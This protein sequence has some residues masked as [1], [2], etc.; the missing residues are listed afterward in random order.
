MRMTLMGTGT[1]HGV[2]VIACDC[3]VCR[4]S[5]KRDKRDRCSAFIESGSGEN[6]TRVL[7]DTGPEFRV[8]ALRYGIKSVDAVLI[9]H[10]HADHL[11]GLDD[12]RI[13]SHTDSADKHN[14]TAGR[15]LP[16]YADAVSVRDIHHRFDYIFHE[17]QLGGGKPKL[18]IIDCDVFCDHNP[19]EIA[20]LSCIPIPMMHGELTTTGWLVR[21]RNLSNDGN[22]SYYS[23]AYL[24][25]CSYIPE[26]SIDLLKES[27]GTIE[28]LVIDGLREELHM[29]HFSFLQAMEMGAK[30]RAK[31]V[32]LTHITHDMS[33]VQIEEYC[34]AHIADTVALAEATKNGTTFAPAYDG[35]VLTA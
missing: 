3:A 22:S 31:H 35:L 13:F 26:S 14:E 12:L 23:I 11:N 2:P 18:D 8:Q 33:Y 1:S 4:S 15:G 20:N 28:H 30:I 5:D 25:D 29:T 32:W 17:T 24:T 9:T 10:G 16:I 7:I 27:G 19:I 6:I 21:E 34:R